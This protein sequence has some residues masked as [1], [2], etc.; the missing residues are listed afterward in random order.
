MT[1]VESVSLAAGAGKAAVHLPDSLFPLD[2]FTSVHDPLYVRVLVL[3]D[4]TT[5]IALTVIDQTSVFDEQVTRTQEIVQRA[6]AVAPSNCLVVASHTFSAPHVLPPDR[7]PRA[8]REKNTRLSRAVDDAVARAAAEALRTLRPARIGSG[9]GSCR[10]AVQRDVPTP[11]GWWLGADDAGPTDD[12]VR[13]IRIDGPEDHPVAVLVNYGVQ[14]SV[15][16]GSTT[17]E[18]GRQVTAD[19]AGVAT[20]RIEERYGGGTVALF[21]VGAAGDQAPYLT[22]VRT[23][24]GD[25]GTLLRTDAHEDGNVL[26]RMLGERLGDEAARVAEGVRTAAPAAPLRVVHGRVEVP[27]QVPPAGLHTLRP[28]RRYAFIPDGTTD[29][30]LV[31]ARLCDCVLVGVQAEL[32]ARTGT[33]LRSA[34]PFPATCVVTMVNGAAKYM[35]DSDSYDRITYGAMNSR[36]GKGAAES[37]VARIVEA[38]HDIHDSR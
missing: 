24:V 18:G 4:G 10:V 19:L 31:V 29:V 11:H 12:G 23:A 9:L 32:N 38:L 8:E 20:A 35:A 27:A 34:S 16:N 7:A 5:R 37:V 14:P 15:M 22:A 30:P 13:V 28:S 21:L 3:D 1:P 33:A 25:D 17:R 2:G 26:A 6:C 36:Y